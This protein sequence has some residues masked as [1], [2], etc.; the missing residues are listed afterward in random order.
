MKGKLTKVRGA[1]TRHTMS[2]R[3]AGAIA[4][5]G[6]SPAA[7][8]LRRVA[9]ELPLM[10]HRNWIVIADSA[11]PAQSRAGIE[12]IATGSD[13]I[14]VVTAVLGML[15]QAR[16]VR[17]IILVDSEMQYVAEESA[18]GITAYREALGRLLSGRAVNPIPHEEL[19]ARLDKAGE[20]FRV[21]ILKTTLTLPYTSVFVQ[22]DC[23]Y[24]SAGAEQKLR[25]TIRGQV[26]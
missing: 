23:G 17:P 7:A 18:P 2:R 5:K 3:G 15:D 10:G 4:R 21:L 22:L 16:H 20:T 11:Y 19:I 24:W 8:W 26:P 6:I 13:Q 9:S 12:T 25:E 1:P 14:E